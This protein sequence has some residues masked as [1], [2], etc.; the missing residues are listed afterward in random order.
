M[1]HPRDSVLAL[2]AVAI[3]S[4]DTPMGCARGSKAAS[5]GQ[6]RCPPRRRR[7][8]TG[9]RPRIFS[10]VS[11]TSTT[12]RSA[13]A[14]PSLGPPAATLATAHPNPQRTMVVFWTPDQR[15]QPVERHL[16]RAQRHAGRSAR[17]GRRAPAR[18]ADPGSPAPPGRWDLRSAARA[19]RWARSRHQAGAAGRGQARQPLGH[20]RSLLDRAPGPTSHGRRSV[21]RTGTQALCANAPSLGAARRAFRPH[22]ALT[23]VRQLR[24]AGSRASA[25]ALARRLRPRAHRSGACAGQQHARL[26]RPG[27]NPR[28]AGSPPAGW[29]GPP[30]ALT[31]AMS[32]TVGR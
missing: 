17:R 29:H 4:R 6:V 23:R 30:A 10:H 32:I 31:P 20:Q 12:S 9:Q 24:R 18:A 13:P 2:G 16:P 14:P 8:H 26:P 22:C 21:R 5:T 3:R 25:A 28:H 27:D 1:L 19:R 7:T 15:P 11:S